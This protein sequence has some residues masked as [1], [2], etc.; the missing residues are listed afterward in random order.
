MHLLG[1]ACA[2]SLDGCIVGCGEIVNDA[3]RHG[4]AEAAGDESGGAEAELAVE[5]LG[6]IAGIGLFKADAPVGMRIANGF[7]GKDA[8]DLEFFLMLSAHVEVAAELL[9]DLGEQGIVVGVAQIGGAD[10]RGIDTSAGAAGDD[11]GNPQFT[12]LR[13]QMDFCV[14]AV[15]G[16]HD[17]REIGGDQRVGVLVGIEVA[18]GVD[19][20]FGI[21]EVNALGQNVDFGAPRSAGHSVDLAVGVGETDVVPVDQREMPDA[22]A[23]QRLADPRADPAHADDQDVGLAQRSDGGFAVEAEQPAKAVFVSAGFNWLGITHG[24]RFKSG[25]YRRGQPDFK[26]EKRARTGVF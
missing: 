11:D 15:D 23:R 9:A 8:G 4:E 26:G 21:D 25:N 12:A 18:D 3:G 6:A 17:I 10:L 20:A 16:I 13:N 22:A 5:L 24:F 7:G 2:G 14:L 1:F 19:G